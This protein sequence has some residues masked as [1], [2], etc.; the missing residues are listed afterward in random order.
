[1]FRA[2]EVEKKTNKRNKP[3]YQPAEIN[4]SLQ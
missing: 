1:M 4:K 3:T 2:T